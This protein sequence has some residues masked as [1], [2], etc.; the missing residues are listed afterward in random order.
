MSYAIKIES[1]IIE[2]RAEGI[3]ISFILKNNNG[4]LIKIHRYN[5]MDINEVIERII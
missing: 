2:T 4:E 5:I 3:L 1:D